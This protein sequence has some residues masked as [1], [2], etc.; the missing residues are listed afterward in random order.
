M[1]NLV[2]VCWNTWQPHGATCSG[3][4]VGASTK[5]MLK[6]WGHLY[7]QSPTTRC[8]NLCLQ[9]SSITEA[10]A[11]W[12]IKFS[13]YSLNY[14]Y[15]LGKACAYRSKST[16]STF[17]SSFPT[18]S[19][20]GLH[21]KTK[22]TSFTPFQCKHVVGSQKANT[23]ASGRDSCDYRWQ[24]Y[25]W[26]EVSESR[27]P[28]T[29]TL[30]ELEIDKQNFILSIKQNSAVYLFHILS[31]KHTKYAWDICHPATQQYKGV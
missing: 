19:I 5:L 16:F 8:Q 28:P 12:F 6:K 20:N 27:A 25:P 9:C 3:F 22:W 15:N 7:L 2:A 21:N 23:L 14:Q 17:V 11:T 13:F 31:R 30:P 29:Q 24:C 26:T 4:V 10:L 1:I 18:S